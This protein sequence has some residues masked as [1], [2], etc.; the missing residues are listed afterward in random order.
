MSVEFLQMNGTIWTYGSNVDSRISVTHGMAITELRDNGYRV[1]ASVFRKG[2][3]YDFQAIGVGLE[4]I[5]LHPF[6]RL[7]V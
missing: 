6:K 7:G 2:C 1:Q 3:G 5:C 4:T